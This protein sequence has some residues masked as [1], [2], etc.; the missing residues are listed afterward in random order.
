MISS[1]SPNISYL[2]LA[3]SL[4]KSA[5]KMVKI[6]VGAKNLLLKVFK[7][8]LG[9]DLKKHFLP[10]FYRLGFKCSW[11]SRL[12]GFFRLILLAHTRQTQTK[13]TLIGVAAK[14]LVLGVQMESSYYS[15]KPGKSNQEVFDSL[16]LY[17]GLSES[18]E[19]LSF[20]VKMIF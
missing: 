18:Q 14:Y 6:F 13:R 19:K 1:D 12:L 20:K 8:I 15:Q 11:S 9:I 10:L 3:Q 16:F 2:C 7:I 17:R 4:T 5:K